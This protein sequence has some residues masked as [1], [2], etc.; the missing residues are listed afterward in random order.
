M[1]PGTVTQRV[2][3]AR[4]RRALA[5]IGLLLFAFAAAAAAAGDEPPEYR[6]KAAFLYN[7]ALFTEWPAGVGPTLNLCVVGKDPFGDEL[8]P[9]QGKKAGARQIAVVRKAGA[10]QLRECQIVFVPGTSIGGLQQMLDAL[11]GAPVLTVT[12]SPGVLGRGMVLNMN[13]VQNRITF[14][15]DLDAARRARLNLSSKL[16]RLATEVRQ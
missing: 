2:R 10:E 5:A 12:D 7:F 13:I 6:L 3:P 1:R 11:R 4:R 8:D 16:L 9:L 15:A 14:E